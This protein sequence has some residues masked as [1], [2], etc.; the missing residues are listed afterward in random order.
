MQRIFLLQLFLALALIGASISLCAQIDVQLPTTPLKFGAF[1]ARF[2]ASGTFT[3]TGT[4]WPAMGGTWKQQG[5]EISLLTA[6]APKGCKG[7][8]RYRARVEGKR[9]SFEVVADDCRPRQMILHGSTWSPAEEAKVI[10]PR[11]I[12]HKSIARPPKNAEAS[13]ANANWPSFRGALA[14]G[15]SEKQNLPDKWDGKSGE[16]ILW[17]TTIP[18][19]AHSSP[20]VWGNRVFVTS[21]VSRDPK[22]TFR[23]GL[24]GDGDASADRSPHKWMLYALDKH[25]GKIL[26][27]RIAHEGVPREKRHIKS[28][29]AS[30]TPATDGPIIVAWFGSQGVFAYDLNGRLLW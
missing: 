3:L 28:T 25:T 5:D 11:N 9:V 22:A 21:A 8:G 15:V 24:Y 14:A 23:P 13:K 2:E 19:L 7:A 10:A 29:Y 30:A 16:N 12:A 6:N 27:E 18:G 20:V 17:R 4:G 26:W 1:T